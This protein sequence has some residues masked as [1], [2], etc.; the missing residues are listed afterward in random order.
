MIEF[1]CASL[2]SRSE[3]F[4][5]TY[6]PMRTASAICV[7]VARSSGGALAP[8]ITPPSATT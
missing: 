8:V 7:G 6:G 1:S 3:N 4:G 2:M 5:I